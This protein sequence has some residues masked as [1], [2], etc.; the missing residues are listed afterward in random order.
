MKAIILLGTLKKHELSNTQVLSEFLA[1]KYE[2]QN[3]RCDI[4]KLVDYNIPPGTYDD[5]G[6]GDE[7]PDILNRILDAQI[8]I[9]ATPIWWGNQSSLMQRAI[10]R[11]DEI[12]DEI[13][14]GKPSE[15]K[16]K[17]GGIVITGDSD[18]IQHIIGNISNFFNAIGILL[19]PFATLAANWEGHR[20]KSRTTRD[21]LWKKYERD[22]TATAEK[23]VSQTIKYVG[24]EFP[25]I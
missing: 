21:E 4:I 22:Y 20:K 19:P 16:G 14:E 9:F 8:I 24:A 5:M 6:M 18:G 23:L 1:Y 2:E 13:M 11:L 15:L 7:W 3:I 10:E 12:H 17:V 25:I